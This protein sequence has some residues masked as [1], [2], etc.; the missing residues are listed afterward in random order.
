MGTA[1]KRAKPGD[2]WRTREDSSLFLGTVLWLANRLRRPLTALGV[3]YPIFRDVLRT[4]VL[5]DLR[6]QVGSAMGVAG[7]ALLVMITGL[8]GLL[9]GSSAVNGSQSTWLVVSQSALLGLLAFYL[10]Q[11]LAGMLVDP[12]DVRTLA[13]HPVPDR[14]LFAVRLVQ[15]FAYLALL[16]TSFTAGNLMVAVFLQPPAVT[17]LAFPLLSLAST[18]TALGLVALAFSVLLRIAG[19]VHFQRITLWAQIGGAVLVTA[20]LQAAPQILPREMVKTLVAHPV[21]SFVWPPLQFARVGDLAAGE[22]SRAGWIALAYTVAVPALAFLFTLRLASRSYIA[23]LA[24]TFEPGSRGPRTWPRGIASLL[25]SLF[26]L[27]REQRAAFEFTAALSRRE[28][29]VLRTVLPQAISFQAMALAMGLSLSRHDGSSS[30][31]LSYSS[32]M[33]AV[34]LPNLLEGCQGSSTPEA[35]WLFLASPV[36]SEA[37]LV[38]GGAKSLL[39]VWYGSF[40][41]L[42]AVLQLCVVGPD[43]VL[44]VLLALEMSAIVAL[45]Y[46]R[47]WSLGVPFTRAPKKQSMDNLGLVMTMMLALGVLGG[48]HWALSRFAVVQAAAVIVLAVPVVLLWRSLDRKPVSKAR[49]LAA[50]GEGG[51]A[52]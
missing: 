15:V 23:G 41:A 47:V 1:T 32:G 7:I 11:S 51:P 3:D 9:T 29:H 38:R 17:L 13:P 34:L 21:T 2:P 46:T 45:A 30:F 49:S 43:E 31:Y 28:S 18:L 14:T 25:A 24:G 27:S 10:T 22:W 26:R 37:E 33:L 36:E 39:A 16:A 48:L 35:R 12:E 52:S 4:R 20:G 6:G 50:G 8:L 5:I 40:L 42:V 44:G 19:P